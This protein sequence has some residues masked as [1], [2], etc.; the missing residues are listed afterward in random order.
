[1]QPTII[2]LFFCLGNFRTTLLGECALEKW[3]KAIINIS[4]VYIHCS[5]NWVIMES[6]WTTVSRDNYWDNKWSKHCSVCF[7]C[8]FW[9]STPYHPLDSA[10][11]S[12]TFWCVHALS[13]LST[14]SV[15]SYSAGLEI[16]SVLWHWVWWKHTL[17][18]GLCT[19]APLHCAA[20]RQLASLRC[21]SHSLPLVSTA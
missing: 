10:H 17:T 12:N 3:W 13:I 1:M 20:G 14:I 7:C 4:Y 6:H 16:R 21:S 2:A 19:L 8:H 5:S 15:Y 11:I 9:G 18:L